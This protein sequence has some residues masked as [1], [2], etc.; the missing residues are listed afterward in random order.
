MT[1]DKRKTIQGELETLT[2]SAQLEGYIKDMRRRDAE[3]AKGWGQIATPLPVQT[4]GTRRWW[5]QDGRLIMQAGEEKK[6]DDAIFLDFSRA[7][8]YTE[9]FTGRIVAAL[10]LSRKYDA[11]VKS[12][13]FPCYWGARAVFGSQN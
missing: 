3:L 5:Q 11:S 7:K 10:R 6:P 8:N 12:S 4:A 2:D 1:T 13:S 9:S